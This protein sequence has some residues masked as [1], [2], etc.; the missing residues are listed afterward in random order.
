MEK[1]L[2]VGNYGY[3]RFIARIYNLPTYRLELLGSPR[4]WR[5]YH[6]ILE[7]MREYKQQ[8]ISKMVESLSLIFDAELFKP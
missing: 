4:M 5:D 2:L 1:P 8:C 6:F 7:A 3:D